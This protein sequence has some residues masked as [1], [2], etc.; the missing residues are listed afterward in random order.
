[1]PR[2]SPACLSLLPPEPR[3]LIACNVSN[4]ST[5]MSLICELCT[6]VK[7]NRESLICTRSACSC[8]RSSLNAST[9]AFRLAT[10]AAAASSATACRSTAISS[11]RSLA[12][13]SPSSSLVTA[14]WRVKLCSFCSSSRSTAWR[15]RTSFRSSS[16]EFLTS[17]RNAWSSASTL[18]EA[19]PCTMSTPA[20]GKTTAQAPKPFTAIAKT[21]TAAAA[22]IAR[23]AHGGVPTTPQSFG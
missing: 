5:R 12:R 14:T 7:L 18:F 20:P 19:D 9:S 16:D 10:S 17:T 3:N 21:L 8:R 23:S 6:W 15:E 1:M 11:A 4:C 22:M 2:V 13:A